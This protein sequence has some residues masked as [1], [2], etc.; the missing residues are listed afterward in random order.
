MDDL[1]TIP[2]YGLGWLDAS[3]P[4]SDIVLSTR[5][6]LARNL[7]GHAFGPRARVNDRE[8]VLS[9]SRAAKDACG[10]LQGATLWELAEVAPRTRQILLERRLV[11]ED[12][13]GGQKGP[14][15]RGSAV[16]LSATETH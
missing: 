10:C 6:R 1:I 11:S 15:A 13:L 8:A 7:Q 3:G 2:D 16:V 4:E 9:Q 14:P 5:V 12:L